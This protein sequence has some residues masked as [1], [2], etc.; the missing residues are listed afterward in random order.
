[1]KCKD[2]DGGSS[3]RVLLLILL[4][5]LMLIVVVVAVLVV[6]V[7]V[8]VYEISKLFKDLLA[9]NVYEFSL[10][11]ERNIVYSKSQNGTQSGL[12]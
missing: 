2:D 8:V 9:S 5:L 10:K 12:T 1:M 11:C 3:G 7:V 6:A 4:L